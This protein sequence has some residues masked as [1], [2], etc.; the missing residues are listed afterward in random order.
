MQ[1]SDSLIDLVG[2]TPLIRLGAMAAGLAV[3]CTQPA[4]TTSRT[5]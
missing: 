3:V 1:V 2:N 4:G 5:R